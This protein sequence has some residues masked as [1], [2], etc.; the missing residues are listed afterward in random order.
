METLSTQ[1]N[2]KKK[3]SSRKVKTCKINPSGKLFIDHEQMDFFPLFL[4]WFSDLRGSQCVIC[5][6]VGHTLVSLDDR[7][8]NRSPSVSA[9]DE[10]YNR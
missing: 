10:L 8:T 3:K 6:S 7:T 9:G 4:K 1:K 5:L 2:V